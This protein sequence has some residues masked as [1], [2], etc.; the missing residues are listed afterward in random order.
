[1]PA[2]K[3]GLT[4]NRYN[5]MKK[6][7]LPFVFLCSCAHAPV[8]SVNTKPVMSS[9]DKIDANLSQADAKSVLIESWIKNSR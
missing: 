9:L 1:V 7:L 2:W 5:Q 4:N 8:H 6:L 3:V